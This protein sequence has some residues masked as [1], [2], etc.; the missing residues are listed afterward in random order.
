MNMVAFSFPRPTLALFSH[1]LGRIANLR[2]KLK[3]GGMLNYAV[4]EPTRDI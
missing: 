1:C 3:K 2:T 4:L